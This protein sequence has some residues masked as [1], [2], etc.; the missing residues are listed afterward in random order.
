M[1]AYKCDRCGKLFES[2]A[3]YQKYLITTISHTAY[4]DLCKE[5]QNE[6]DKWMDLFKENI[7]EE[8]EVEL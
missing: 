1:K 5:C 8:S 3:S 6:L 7:N 2:K 4:S